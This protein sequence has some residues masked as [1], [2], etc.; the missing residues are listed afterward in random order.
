MQPSVLCKPYLYSRRCYGT[1]P[2]DFGM[3]HPASAYCGPRVMLWCTVY[4]PA[5]SCGCWLLHAK[6]F[7]Y[8]LYHSSA[9]AYIYIGYIISNVKLVSKK[10]AQT[11]YMNDYN[12][13]ELVKEFCQ[14][15]D[16]PIE[17]CN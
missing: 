6:V 2:K 8:C 3:E 5:N 14:L 13:D 10:C 7:G 1:V 9:Y 12:N 15:M 4:L 17:R 11:L 16:V